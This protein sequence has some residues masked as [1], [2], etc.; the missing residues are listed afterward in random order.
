MYTNDSHFIRE[1]L[2]LSLS[3]NFR[4]IAIKFPFLK[5][6]VFGEV[7]CVILLHVP[8]HM[9]SLLYLTRS[10]KLDPRRFGASLGGRKQQA[11]ASSSV[12]VGGVTFKPMKDATPTSGRDYT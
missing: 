11:A 4:N 6:Y 3:L 1:T 2:H 8:I 9:A 7:I 10:P 5:I 12:V